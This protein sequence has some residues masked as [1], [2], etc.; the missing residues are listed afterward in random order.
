M[1]RSTDATLSGYRIKVYRD[2]RSA[3]EHDLEDGRSV[4]VGSSDSCGIQIDGMQVAGIHCLIEV[5]D[6]K[7]FVQDWASEAGTKINGQPIEDK[8][9]LHSGDTLV[10]GQTT[11]EL[12]GDPVKKKAP[13][14][15]TVDEEPREESIGMESLGFDEVEQAPAVAEQLPRIHTSDDR[16]SDVLGHR[17]ANPETPPPEQST[18][19]DLHS[20]E[21]RGGELDDPFEHPNADTDF[22]ANDF[23]ANRFD[24][25]SLEDNDVA[26]LD[27]RVNADSTTLND[28]TSDQGEFPDNSLTADD[29]D[30]DPESIDDDQIDPEIVQLLKSE[31][32]D[33]R[34]QLAERD[35]QLATIEGMQ[36]DDAD[37]VAKATVGADAYVGE[38]L[39]GRVDELLAELEE[40]DERVATL[41]ELLQTAEIQ[42]QAER[43]ERNCLETWVGEIEQRIGQRESEWQAEQDGLRQRLD[44]ACEERDRFQQKLH[45]AAKRFGKASVEDEVPDETLKQLQEQ[46]ATLQSSVEESQ[47]QCASLQRQV[48]RLKTEEPDSLQ[49]ERAELAKEKAAVSRMRFE[50]SKQLQDIGTEEPTMADGPDREFAYKLQTLRE[51]L[52]EIHEEERLEREHRGESLFGRISGLWKRVEDRY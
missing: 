8:T 14:E 43:E 33:L 36:D 22:E 35:E 17:P 47:K 42:N 48:E 2:N 30:W 28:D 49:A 19:I 7:V 51:H 13:S 12:I 34:I 41:Q 21:E 9:E 4:F 37:A 26:A 44:L 10:V 11:L 29:L 50:L 39:V 3:L 52:R 46:N 6:Q 15:E 20:A 24:E 18:E 40:H 31:I 1:S 23:E 45:A 25:N 5:E 16:L 27:V 32:E 38:E